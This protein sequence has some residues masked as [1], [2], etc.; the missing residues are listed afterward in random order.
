MRRSPGIRSATATIPAY[1]VIG[2]GAAEVV[3]FFD[4]QLHL[5]LMWT[6]LHIHSL[7][8]RMSTYSRAVYFQRRGFESSDP[9]DHVPT[10]EEQDA[11]H[12]RRR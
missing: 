7:L 1:G 10:L 4:V 8:E 3:W 9:V 6:D 11:R 12:H 2:A 5:D